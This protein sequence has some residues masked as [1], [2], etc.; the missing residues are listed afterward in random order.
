MGYL[1]G[2]GAGLCG[3]FEEAF[4]TLEKKKAV[5]PTSGKTAKAYAAW[6]KLLDEKPATGKE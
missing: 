2:I 4:Q 6:K 5:F 3:S 1:L